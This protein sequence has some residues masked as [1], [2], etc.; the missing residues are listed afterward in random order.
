MKILTQKK[1]KK[2]LNFN[3]KIYN[4]EFLSSEKK[5]HINVNN[6]TRTLFHISSTI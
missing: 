1:K 2:K 4:P 5:N 6:I 3:L